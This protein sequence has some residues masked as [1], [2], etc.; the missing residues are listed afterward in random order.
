MKNSPIIYKSERIWSSMD[1]ISI[2]KKLLVEHLGTDN[3]EVQSNFKST[4]SWSI[5][6][7]FGEFI[8]SESDLEIFKLGLEKL[9]NSLSKTIT[10]F[11]SNDFAHKIYGLLK[12]SSDKK[13]FSD[14]II[15]IPDGRGSEFME[16]IS[17]CIKMLNNEPV[18]ETLKNLDLTQLIGQWISIKSDDTPDYDINFNMTDFSPS[19]SEIKILFTEDSNCRIKIPARDYTN[20]KATELIIIDGD[21]EIKEG[22]IFITQKEWTKKIPV[23]NIVDEELKVNLFKTNITF[24]K[25]HANIGYN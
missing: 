6:L 11:N 14:F 2:L 4:L 23:L 1:F 3:S 9:K 17:T 7:N 21:C 8:S 22:T 13:E 20:P 19:Y 10:D 5:D 12:S 18:F 25:R 15:K 24:K 16:L